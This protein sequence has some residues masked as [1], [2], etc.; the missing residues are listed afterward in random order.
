MQR[1]LKNSRNAAAPHWALGCALAL[2][3]SASWAAS[4]QE[5][6]QAAE[7]QKQAYLATLKTLVNIESGSKDINGLN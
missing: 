3:A 2:S 1:T 6:K 4:P 5:I 7:S